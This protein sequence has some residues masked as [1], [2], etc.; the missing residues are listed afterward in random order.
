MDLC[1]ELCLAGCLSSMVKTVN[2][3]HYTQMSEFFGL[4]FFVLLFK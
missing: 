3:G 4:G 1:I 2:V